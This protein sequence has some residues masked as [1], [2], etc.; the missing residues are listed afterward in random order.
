MR[1]LEGRLVAVNA[2][3]SGGQREFA[4]AAGLGISAVD[5]GIAPDGKWAVRII[6][7]R[8]SG[9]LRI[10]PVLADGSLGDLRPF[11]KL[12]PE[13]DVEEAAI[14]PDGKLL[15][16]VTI[17]A[18]QVYNLFLTRFPEGTGRWQVGTEGGRSPRWAGDSGELFF[19]AGSGTARRTMVSVKVDP[20]L[21]PPP[22]DLARLFELGSGSDLEMSDS[23]RFDVTADGRRF[24]F[25]HPAGRTG[26]AS[27][28]MVLVQNW[29]AEFGE[30]GAR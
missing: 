15:A 7:Q 4:P 27:Q 22:G 5:F 17:D 19:I 24:L 14:S 13:P 23:N 6:D 30:H 2:D 16:Y 20:R 1:N 21:D 29:R 28:R 25:I 26:T 11:L 10:G 8:G 9:R 3:G 12:E 18:G